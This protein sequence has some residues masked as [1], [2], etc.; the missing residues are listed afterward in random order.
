VLRWPDNR[1]EQPPELSLFR[2][3][4]DPCLFASLSLNKPIQNLQ[5][6]YCSGIGEKRMLIELPTI[7]QI[8]PIDWLYSVAMSSRGFDS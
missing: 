7:F 3:A 1:A 4:A 6:L 2:G 8:D 5:L